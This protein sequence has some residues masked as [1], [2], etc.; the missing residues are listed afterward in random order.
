MAWRLLFLPW[1]LQQVVEVFQLHRFF[2]QT[3]ME[4]HR[5]FLVAQW[6][7][8]HALTAGGMGLITGR[9]T[10]IPRAAWHSQNIKIK[11]IWR[12]RILRSLLHCCCSKSLQSC[13]TLC[14]PMGHSLPGFSVHGI[15]QAKM[16]EWVSIPS[17]TGYS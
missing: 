1:E 11:Q 10:K 16:L 2:F 15:F 4:S 5:T 14:H 9:G 13:L 17:S 12:L 6:L 7:R 8:L 3:D